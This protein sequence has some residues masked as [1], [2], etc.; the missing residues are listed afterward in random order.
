M[1][2]AVA[3]APGP[4]AATVD[5]TGSWA[6]VVSSI[7]GPL[8]VVLDFVQ[9]GTQLSL[10]YTFEG[11]S[12]QGAFMGTIDPDTGT[13][14][15]PLPDSYGPFPGL[16]CTGNGIF[17]G[18][19][20]GL[21]M[22]GSWVSRFFKVTPPAG[23]FDGGGPFT[24]TRIVCGNGV[25]DPGEACD[26]GGTADGDC[27]SADCQT[28]ASDGASCDDGDACTPTDQCVGGTCVGSG[29]LTCDP[30]EVCTPDGGCVVPIARGCQP[31]LATKSSIVLRHH[32]TDPGKDKIT[33]AWRSSAA[34]ALADFGSPLATADY[35]LCVIEQ[36]GGVLRSSR[37]APAG[38]V[39]GS[40]SC[41]TTGTSALRYRDKEGTP[42]GLS[43]ITLRAG[44]DVGRGKITVKGKGPLLD[45]PALGFT[46]PVIVRLVRDD[47]SVCW[48]ATYSTAQANDAQ[49]FKA[50]SD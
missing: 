44:A 47:A 7:V 40:R 19:P 24:G 2:L 12:P 32:G 42:E 36:G 8:T 30:C 31:A 18:S 5:L 4:A 11:S 17:G 48:E 22:S 16:V 6:V 14:S 10:T 26:D 1:A 25:V 28:V 21:T 50:R 27:C 33:W 41:W 46:P 15:V 35:T 45:L 39:C 9:T 23:C 49:T 43:A 3:L 13:F 37:T 34:V 38:G 29:I 20:D